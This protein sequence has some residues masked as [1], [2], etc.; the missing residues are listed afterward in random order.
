MLKV[1]I[2][3][4]IGSGKSV[5]A[6]LFSL[7]GTPVYDSDQRAKWLIENDSEIVFNIKQLLGNESYSPEGYY[8]KSFVSQKVFNNN[9]LLLSLNSIV[10]PAVRKDFEDWLNIQKTGFVIKEAAIMNRDAG[11]DKIIVVESPKELRIMRLLKRDSHRDLNQ[12]EK[13]I[14]NQKT[15][16]EFK[17]MADFVVQNNEEILIIPQVLDIYQKLKL[18]S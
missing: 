4:G 9:D 11:L 15:A 7:L 1:G 16:D 8:N 3:G 5:V 18:I 13:V 12:L 14:S 17:S 6:R 2:T 10:H